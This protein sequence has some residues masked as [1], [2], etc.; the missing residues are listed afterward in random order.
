MKMAWPVLVVAWKS[1]GSRL[2]VAPEDARRAEDWAAV[3]DLIVWEDGHG[4]CGGWSYDPATQ[5]MT[6]ACG[7]VLFEVGDPVKAVA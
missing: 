5:A 6:C 1:E 4:F 7:A 2:P 3:G